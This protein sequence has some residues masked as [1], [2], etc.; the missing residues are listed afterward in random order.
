MPALEILTPR[1]RLLAL[2]PQSSFA[3]L[4]DRAE[5]SRLIDADVPVEWPPH[6]LADV[7]GML[8]SRLA[9]HPDEVGWW[10]WYVIALPGVV[11][12]GAVPGRA[13]LIGSAG[14]SRWGPQGI[15]QFGYGLLPAFYRRGFAT[16][17]ATNL[18]AWVMAQ[19]VITRV[20][21]TTFERHIAS[22][23]ILER[24]GFRNCGVSPDDATA[25]ESDRQGRGK[26][27]L[28]VRERTG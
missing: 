23:K 18:I 2:T 14:C 6:D 21:A 12:P 17:A 7:Q 1:L 11:V 5:F 20:E 26:L 24:C 13:T 28:F 19:P 4:K 22:V 10:G 27:I 25:A 3:A 15:P 16:E 9:E 8:A